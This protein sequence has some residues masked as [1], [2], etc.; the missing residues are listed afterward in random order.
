MSPIACSYRSVAWRRYH[1]TGLAPTGGNMRKIRIGIAAAL[2]A[3]GITAAV[4]A[5]AATETI[6]Q[7]DVNTWFGGN[8]GPGGSVGTVKLVPGP[9]TPPLGQGSAQLTVDDTGRASLGTNEFRGTRLDAITLLDFWG[10][11]VNGTTNQL[12]L[13][14]D[15]D[16]DSTNAST[17]FQGRLTFVPSTPPPSNAWRHLDTFT[18]G[19][20]FATGAPG[21]T[22]CTQASLCTWAQILT[23]FPD[24]A[25]RNDSIAK[26][27][28]L[29]RLGGPIAGGAT[30]YVDTLTLT[31]TTGS[32]T[33]DF[34]PG[35]SVTPSVGPM[36]TN[37]TIEAYGFK[38]GTKATRAVLHR[39]QAEADAVPLHRRR[40]RQGV[41]RGD[42]PR[43]GQ[44]GRN[45]GC[46][47]DPHRRS[48]GRSA[49]RAAVQPGLRPHAVANDDRWTLSGAG[50]PRRVQTV[51][52]DVR[53][54]DVWE[55]AAMAAAEW[56]VSG[57]AARVPEHVAFIEGDRRVTYAQLEDRTNRLAH[58]LAARGVG[59]GDRIAIKLPNSI[60]FFEVWIAA[61]KLQAA[62]VLVN[63]H[64]LPDEVAYIVS[65]SQASL[66][67]DDLQR[68]EDMVA[69]GTPGTSGL[70]ACEVLAPPVFYTS[71]T[72][73]RPK[74]V[75]HGAPGGAFSGDRARMAQQGQV[76]LWSWCA[77]DVYILSGPA[78]HAGPG[79]FV[80]SALFVGAT[81]VILTRWNAREWLRL[82]DR[83]RVTLTF[84]TPAHFIRLLEVPVDERARFDT[85][86]LRLVVHGAAPCPVDVKR[87]IIDALPSAEVWELYGASEGARRASHRPSGWRGP[88]ASACRGPVS[89]CGSSTTTAGRCRWGSR[90]SCTS[91][92]RAG[93]AFTTTMIP[94]R[95]HARGET[96]STMR[97]EIPP[98]SPSATSA[99]STPTA[100]SSSPI[101][102]PTW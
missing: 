24:A 8:E 44:E 98:R 82:V 10:Y 99:T 86:S 75:I 45:R 14:F 57:H 97:T 76:A 92:R 78:Y 60:A 46:T 2:V 59:E 84:M 50:T 91:A 95:P 23:A 79:G 73:G 81:S 20:W 17:A 13:G 85:S 48:Q 29:L 90:A 53:A 55:T 88:A 100:I 102:R 58:A 89:R 11:V 21:N 27:A 56:G 28:L 64:L 67:V 25:I 43:H 4:P 47:P 18:D 49:E 65:D 93:R 51:V 87:R 9:A 6:R 40:E 77:D 26:G 70:V 31:T 35:T 66:L 22:V 37:V 71:G 3:L 15:V 33:A 69:T 1:A 72:T 41:V 16:Y 83:H 68:C 36:G 63:T 80:M 61:A 38:P 54:G 42:D 5:G 19:T 74:G 32:T 62:V 12:V 7:L 52:E 39:H 94:S 101:G 34:E 96:M 30:A